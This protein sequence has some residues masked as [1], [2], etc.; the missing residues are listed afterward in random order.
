MTVAL[1]GVDEALARVL[2]EIAPVLQV[3]VTDYVSCIES[4]RIQVL[5][6]GFI[7]SDLC[8]NLLVQ[9]LTLTWKQAL[10]VLVLMGRMLRNTNLAEELSNSFQPLVEHIIGAMSYPDEEVRSSAA[11]VRVWRPMG[12]DIADRN[13]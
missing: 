9:L 4:I 10:F 3:Y 12:R 11:F 6:I 13:R 2:V 8:T 7:I 1:G 5:R